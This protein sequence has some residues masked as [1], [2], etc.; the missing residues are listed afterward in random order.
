MQAG[1][2]QT[3]TV[4]INPGTPPEFLFTS[5]SDAKSD[6][7][8]Y[9]GAWFAPKFNLLTGSNLGPQAKETFAAKKTYLPGDTILFDFKGASPATFDNLLLRDD[10][11]DMKSF[12]LLAGDAPD[13][14]KLVGTYETRARNNVDSTP[15]EINF[16]ATTAKYFAMRP[17]SGW[18]GNGGFKPSEAYGNPYAGGI[19]G[20]AKWVF[21]SGSVWLYGWLEK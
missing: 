1:S 21:G 9:H 8:F 14:L 19:P 2:K 5:R 18:K 6:T 16:P 7:F 13:A 15:L 12:E 11:D 17:L 20:R 10:L 4:E 3:V